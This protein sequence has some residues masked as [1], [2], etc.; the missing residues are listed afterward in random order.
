MA[1][2]GM[3]YMV[4]VICIFDGEDGRKETTKCSTTWTCERR[5]KQRKTKEEMDGQC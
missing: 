2:G 4:S 5:H 3:D 1:V